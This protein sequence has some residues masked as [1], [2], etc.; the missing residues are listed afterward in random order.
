MPWM[1]RAWFVL[2]GVSCVLP[3]LTGCGGAVESAEAAAPPVRP[4][5]YTVVNRTGGKVVDV[6]VY[7]EGLG[8]DLGYG[9]IAENDSE[10]L[11][12]EKLTIPTMV[13]IDFTMP[14]GK[15][16]YNKV[17]LSRLNNAAQGGPVTLTLTGFGRVSASR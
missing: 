15:R 8:R 9:V 17:S 6:V 14:N 13:E 7:G 12:H 16:S 4:V 1:L 5:S 2:F 11:R 10:T 3:G